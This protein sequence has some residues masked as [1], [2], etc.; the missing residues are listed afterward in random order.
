MAQRIVFADFDPVLVARQ[1]RHFHGL[2]FDVASAAT[3]DEL[4]HEV[5]T[6]GAQVIVADIAF[7]TD[8]GQAPLRQIQAENGTI[9]II[10]TVDAVSLSEFL[11]CMRSGVDDCVFKPFD[12]SAL[13][14]SVRIGCA[15]HQQWQ[16]HLRNLQARRYH[17]GFADVTA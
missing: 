10:M 5:R 8:D 4:V 14:A 9:H 1:Q 13:E 12:E 17:H 7:L 16:Q 11:L 15:R 3:P 6:A 2:G